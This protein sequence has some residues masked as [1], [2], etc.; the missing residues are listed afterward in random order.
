MTNKTQTKVKKY[1][2]SIVI[3]LPK[4]FFNDSLFPFELNDEVC[5]AISE[6]QVVIYKE[7]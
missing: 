5:L 6:G 4:D 7:D 3:S 2:N 1:G